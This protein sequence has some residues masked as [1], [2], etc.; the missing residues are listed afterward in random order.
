M[1]HQIDAVQRELITPLSILLPP[2]TSGVLV[3][4]STGRL[5]RCNAVYISLYR[6]L[7]WGSDIT[8]MDLSLYVEM[9]I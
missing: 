3:L 1:T 8:G 2:L 5:Q 7:V 6:S 4:L 9:S